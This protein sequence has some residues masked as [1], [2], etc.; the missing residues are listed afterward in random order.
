ML[1][2]LQ[3]GLDSAN[4]S[5]RAVN[6]AD[7]PCF[8]GWSIPHL[9]PELTSKPMKTH[10]SEP[11][12]AVSL[13]LWLFVYLQLYLQHH[14]QS[15]NILITCQRNANPLAVT[16]QFL[17]SI[18][19]QPL[20]YF[21]SLQICLVWTFNISGVVNWSF[22]IGLMYPAVGFG[23]SSPIY[24][25]R[26][27]MGSSSPKSPGLWVWEILFYHFFRISSLLPLFFPG[28]ITSGCWI[29]QTESLFTLSSTI[30]QLFVLF[31]QR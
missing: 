14:Y 17:H 22:I 28:N 29:T 7:R 19:W 15:S 30:S 6:E 31:S 4:S 20:T 5:R 13:F 25:T 26:C 2:R 21:L 12:L 8:R 18:A 11:L 27:L 23:F 9:L 24:C 3:T 10:G 1:Q 16:S